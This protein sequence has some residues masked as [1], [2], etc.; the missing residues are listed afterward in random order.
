MI[1]GK[2]N[3]LKIDKDKMYKGEKGVYLDIVLIPVQNQFG[4]DY[5]IVQDLGKEARER[6]EKGAILGNA[7]IL[8]QETTQTQTPVTAPLPTDDDLPF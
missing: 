4:D 6:G 5:M 1:K 2:I 8:K 3:V 7:K